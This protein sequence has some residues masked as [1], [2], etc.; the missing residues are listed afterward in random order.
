MPRRPRNDQ[1]TVSSGL[2]HHF[3]ASTLRPCA[4][5]GLGAIPAHH[6]ARIELEQVASCSVY[7]DECH[8]SHHSST[9]RPTAPAV[10][11]WD[12]VITLRRGD[13]AIAVEPHPA[14]ADQVATMIE[15]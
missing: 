13:D 2:C 14:F 10:K 3:A 11:R 4:R 5:G 15:K 1:E 7:L 6:R 9:N 12:Y 8:R